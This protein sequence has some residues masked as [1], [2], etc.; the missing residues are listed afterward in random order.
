MPV[1]INLKKKYNTHFKKRRKPILIIVITVA[2]GIVGYILF[3]T[4]SSSITQQRR[5]TDVTLSKK[6]T[7][8]G[9]Q[10]PD[11]TT[12]LPEGKTVESLGGWT[13]VSPPDRNPVF[14]YLDTLDGKPINV[15]QQPLPPELKDDKGRQD[16]SQITQLSQGYNANDKVIA[17]RTTIYIGT[18][19]KGPQ[20]IIFGKNNLL[21]LIK[22]SV[23]LTNDQWIGYVNSLK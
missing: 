3:L 21:I 12:L 23:S 18:S 19:A 7:G 9:L 15:S 2:L 16:D 4:V 1:M 10:S 13:R 11:Y 5:A 8:A 22:S 20:S 6:Y 14:A 17:G